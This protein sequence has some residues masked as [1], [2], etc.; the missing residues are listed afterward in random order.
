M[1]TPP[2]P[3]GRGTDG[4]GTDGRGTDGRGNSDVRRHNLS[5][6]LR[7]VHLSRSIPR[8]GLTRS[9]GLNRSTIAALVGELVERELLVE[10][11]P[12]ANNQVGRPS[13]LVLPAPRPIAFAVNPEIDAITVGV[14]GLGATVL[15]RVRRPLDH[16]PSVA[17]AVAV[18]AELVAELRRDFDTGHT[19]LGIGA[20]VPGLVRAR[21]GVVRLAPHLDW[22]D[23][24]FAAELEAAIG[25]PV[26]AANDANLGT[27]AESLFGAGRGVADLIYLNG[28][29]SGIGGGIVSGGRAISGIEGYAGEFGHMQVVTKGIACHCG[30]TGCLETV[31]RRDRLLALTG[32]TNGDSDELEAALIAGES[33]DIRAEALRQLDFLAVA[34]RN[35][36]NILNPSKIVLGGF[37]GTLYAVAPEHLDRLV[38][39]QPL[40]ASSELVTIQRSELG[41]NRLMIGAAELV[42]EPVLDDPSSFSR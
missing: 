38:A 27:K 33:P 20:A 19:I 23:E 41:V 2:L 12:D 15:R 40:A 5:L 25:L 16:S 36:V 9:T 35:A 39:T 3:D 24:P 6:V 37:L 42:F 4:R 22:V 28:G 26:F 30:A 11:E 10:A 29:P 1:S 34:L 8:S 21:D 13:P 18:T 31:V 17:D 14:V 32:L 7:L